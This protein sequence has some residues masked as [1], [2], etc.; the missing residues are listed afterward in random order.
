MKGPGP[1][2]TEVS[3]IFGSVYAG[4]CLINL[5]KHM[6]CGVKDRRETT[7]LSPFAARDYQLGDSNTKEAKRRHCM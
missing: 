6:R 7:F 5:F 4:A 1:H 2:H 3:K